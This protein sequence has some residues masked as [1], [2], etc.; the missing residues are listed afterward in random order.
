M[1]SSAN[2]LAK[3]KRTAFAQMGSMVNRCRAQSALHP[4]LC[5]CSVIVASYSS[6]H[7]CTRFTKASRPNS[8]RCCPWAN[9]RFSTT[10]WVAIPA[11]SVPGIHRTSYPRMRWCRAKMSWSVLLNAC[12][13][14]RAAVTFGG[15]ISSVYAGRSVV[16]SACP[17]FAASQASRTEG[18]CSLGT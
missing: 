16:G 13:R 17:T 15:G 5:S 9:S 6:F 2:N 11:W 4:R 8:V 18:S 7:C 10:V 12:P 1:R 14:C 3:A